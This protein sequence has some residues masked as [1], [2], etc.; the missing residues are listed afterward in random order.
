MYVIFELH[1]NIERGVGIRVPVGSRIFST[2][3]RP[4]RLWGPPS[5]YPVGTGALSPGLKRQGREADHSPSTS[6]DVNKT[7]IYTSTLPY[8]FM[9]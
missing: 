8:V 3:Y 4:D 5:L 6:A 7:W 2:P 9:A 1:L